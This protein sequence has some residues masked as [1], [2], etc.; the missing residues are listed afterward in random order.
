[1]KL[2]TDYQAA[3]VEAR[4]HQAAGRFLDA[5]RIFRHLARPGAHRHF[6]LEALADL[7]LQQQ[8]FE[9][10]LDIVRELTDI[11]PDN[12]HYCTKLANLLDS[13]G[14]TDDAIAEYSRLLQQ[15]PD[16][17]LAHFNIAL[18]Y[19]KL[20][21]YAEA[22]SAYEEAVRLG[23]DRVE[24]VYS[25]MG[26]V[27]SE[28]LDADKTREM[29]QRAIDIAPEYVPALFHL[30][31]HYEE[32]G[33]SE[34]A[35]ELYERVQSIDPRHW[36][37]LARLAYPKKVTAE[38]ESLVNRLKDGIEDRKDDKTAQE[39]LHF[40]LGKAYDDLENYDEAA[41][42]FVSANE[43]S[44]QRVLPYV[45]E[46]TE[47]AFGQLI[48]LFD[49]G[50][51][52]S[53]E[54]D[55]DV[56]PVFICGMYRSGSTLLERMLSGHPA[57]AAGGELKTLAWLVARYLGPFPQGVSDATKGQ[58]RHIADEYNRSVSKLAPDAS[59]ITDKRLDNFL[60][61]GLARAIFPTTKIIQTR[62]DLR[63]N[64]LSVYFHQ[65]S[66]VASY[67]N[68]LE[69]IAHYSKQQERLFAHWRECFGDSICTVDYEELIDSPET[70][71]RGVVEFL[72]LEW[73]PGVL[74]FQ[75]SGGLV[76]THSIWQVREGLHSRSRDRWRNYETLLGSLAEQWLA[77]DK[78]EV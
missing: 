14:R 59:L 65:F 23:I 11:V 68:N 41:A 62:R 21:R 63:D 55:S 77:T 73:D 47:R 13:L 7:F 40:A 71:L 1:M 39:V 69:H 64:C 27:Y 29:Y 33:E 15:R 43:I 76:R 53:K 32:S 30:A 28:M 72:G 50:W 48:D 36:E 22:L 49:S 31:N 54:T 42:A 44:R 25:N 58:L 17:V 5:E 6:A 74:D 45:P 20:D 61:L 3:F 35:V 66:R 8:R 10:C 26:N 2:P 52:E 57:I 37:S 16:E 51:I 24:E 18:L 4:Q 56:S 19:R 9:E 34:L 78:P 12:V 67:A 46:Q 70:V 75:N 38:D 60:R